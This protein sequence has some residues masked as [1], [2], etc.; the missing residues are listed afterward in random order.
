MQ[1]FVVAAFRRAGIEDS[2][3]YVR[4]DASFV[5]PSDAALQLGDA[6]PGPHARWAGRRRSASRSWSGGW[7][8]PTCGPRGDR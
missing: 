1:D 3:R 6:D 5:R 8:T 7:S 4:T 2:E